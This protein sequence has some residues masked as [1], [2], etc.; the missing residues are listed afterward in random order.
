MNDKI[1]GH[2]SVELNK[3]RRSHIGKLAV[4]IISGYKGI[5]L[6]EYLATEVINLAKK[7]LGT[8]IIQLEVYVDNK[9]AINLYK[10]LG[11]KKVAR[12][13]KQIQY[14]GKLIDKFIMIK[15]T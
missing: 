8:K 10:K 9:S 13:P 1:V 2:V 15:Y 5:G 6:G 3:Y 11:F 14:K 7:E 4:G 12:L